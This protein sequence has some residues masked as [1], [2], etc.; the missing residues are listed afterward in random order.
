MCNSEKGEINLSY[1]GASWK[2]MKLEPDF[3][4]W[5]GS[6]A[7]VVKPCLDLPAHAQMSG[8]ACMCPILIQIFSLI[9]FLDWVPEIELARISVP[10]V[11]IF[12]CQIHTSHSLSIPN[13]N[14]LSSNYYSVTFSL[15]PSPSTL[16]LPV[17]NFPTLDA[18]F[19][20]HFLGSPRTCC[21][22]VATW[23]HLLCPSSH[24]N[25]CHFLTF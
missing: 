22:S 3:E 6:T 5:V 4:G 2:R 15:S 12:S 13:P 9:P 18:F 23:C 25:N 24:P 7:A 10:W 11:E 14:A 1:V 19:S 16:S 17:R 8:R 20:C 21:Q